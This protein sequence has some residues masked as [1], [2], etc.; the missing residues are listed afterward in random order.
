MSET[1]T[2]IHT[3]TTLQTQQTYKDKYSNEKTNIL[4]IDIRSNIS[5]IQT[6]ECENSF[7]LPSHMLRM[8]KRKEYYQK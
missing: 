6:P 2:A 1:R 7:I 3:L 5:S 4:C 8:L